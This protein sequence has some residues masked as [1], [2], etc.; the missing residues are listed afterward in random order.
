MFGIAWQELL[1]TT[2]IIFL[3]IAVGR[4]PSIGRSLGEAIREFR[5]FE[6]KP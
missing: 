1:Q 2:L 6:K 5:K 3:F 4:I